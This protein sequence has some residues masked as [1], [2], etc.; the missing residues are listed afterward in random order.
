MRSIL[1]SQRTNPSTQNFRIT[2]V[3]SLTQI[4]IILAVCSTLLLAQEKQPKKDIAPVSFKK[5]VA[6]ILD[7]YC[8]GCHS[9]DEEHPSQLY[10][11]SYESLMKGGKNS[12][13]IK[14]GDSKESL[15]MQKMS[16]NPPF[17]KIM[18]PP[19]KKAP[20]PEQIE[21]IRMWI[22]QGAKKN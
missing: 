6:P 8:T 1:G 21:V 13:S 17:G 22:D 12:A 9:A 20:T 10:L 7:K 15:F 18:P 4:L 5:D 19:R 16:A 11:D 2:P 14:Q 3:K